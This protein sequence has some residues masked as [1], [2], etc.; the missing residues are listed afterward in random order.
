MQIWD[1]ATSA[2]VGTPR[3]LRPSG[4]VFALI[5]A[6]QGRVGRYL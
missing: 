2:Q 6:A 1:E 5:L 3:E 4:D